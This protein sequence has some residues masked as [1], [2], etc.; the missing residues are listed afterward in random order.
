MHR[1]H[2]ICY[3]SKNLKEQENNFATNDLELEVNIHV[4]KMW[5]HYLVRIFF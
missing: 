5:S 1:K 4:L 3:E 2:V